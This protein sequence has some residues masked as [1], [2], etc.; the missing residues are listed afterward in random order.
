MKMEDQV[1]TAESTAIAKFVRPIED[2]MIILTEGTDKVQV[3]SDAQYSQAGQVLRVVRDNRKALTSYF[4]EPPKDADHARPGE[5]LCYFARKA[6]DAANSLFN[7]FD[8]KF[9]AWDESLDGSMRDYRA[10]V[11]RKAKAEAEAKASAERKRLADEAAAQRAEAE[12]ERKRL[13][14]IAEQERKRADAERLKRL[15]AEREAARGKEQREAAER[16]AR[17]EQQRIEAEALRQRQEAEA[18][19]AA[20]NAEAE[21]KE[22]EA[23]NVVAT[24]VL[25]APRS[26]DVSIRKSWRA[27]VTDLAKLVEAAAANKAL[28]VCLQVDQAGCDGL[29]K[30]YKGTNPPP[31]LRFVQKEITASRKAKG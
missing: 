25:E 1:Q 2:E 8:G 21:L 26:E 6:W 19:E 4:K 16:R 3:T 5:G 23:Q 18:Q 29:A 7:K 17:E 10:E 11:E 14:A 27:E 13:E 24:V 30:A 20:Q 31:G 12:R 9:K 28:L 22:E 15:T